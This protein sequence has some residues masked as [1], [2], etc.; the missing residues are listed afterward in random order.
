MFDPL[1]WNPQS[2]GWGVFFYGSI[3][4]WEDQLEWPRTKNVVS[5]AKDDDERWENVRFLDRP[6]NDN[7]EAGRFWYFKHAV[8]LDISGVNRW[9]WVG[10][11]NV[12]CSKKLAIWNRT[13]ISRK[14]KHSW[15]PMKLVKYILQSFSISHISP[16]DQARA[17]TV[18]WLEIWK[19][20]LLRRS[21]YAMVAIQAWSGQVSYPGVEINVTQLFKRY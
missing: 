18:F 16:L 15:N 1:G 21:M 14:L 19:S 4:P 17:T 8:I 6:N 20:A 10:W 3:Y 7:L 13:N 2:A 12:Q 5:C 9:P 11:T